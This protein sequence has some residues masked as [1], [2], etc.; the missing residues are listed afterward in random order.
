[1]L[2]LIAGQ[3]A[4]PKHI[5]DTAPEPPLIAS[6]MRFPPDTLTP[7]ITLRIETL[8]SALN[9]LKDKGVT[10]VCFA[11][12]L[13]RHPIEP[14]EIDAATMPLVPRMAEAL[15]QG[16]DAALRTVIAIFEE[17]GLAV[18]AAHDIAPDLLPPSGILTEA[19]PTDADEADATRAA[20]VL[21]ALGPADVGQGCVVYRRQVLA[22]EAHYGTDWMLATLEH[23]PDNTTGGTYYKAPK[24]GQDRRI[25]LPAIGPD[26]VHA[27]ADAGLYGIAIEAGG[28]MILD[29]AKCVELADKLGLFLWVRDP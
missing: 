8:G 5:A 24:P 27:A 21:A 9:L 22:V 19:P 16:D 4:L 2:A 14:A 15:Q 3:G 13:R 12:A 11:G 10:E 20:Q 6:L 25:D 17:A 7:D 1:M 28:V 23:R 29:R 26:T 18:K